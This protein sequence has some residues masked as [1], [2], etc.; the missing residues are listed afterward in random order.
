M[1]FPIKKGITDNISVCRKNNI[2]KPI[3]VKMFGYSIK[4]PNTF[5]PDRHSIKIKNAKGISQSLRSYC[6]YFF[7]DDNSNIFLLTFILATPAV[8]IRTKQFNPR[9]YVS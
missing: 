3:T 6:L 4:S 8:S 5:L 7:S 1:I 2:T 9:I